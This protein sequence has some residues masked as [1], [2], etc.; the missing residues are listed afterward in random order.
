[1]TDSTIKRLAA[2]FT[3]D[4]EAVKSKPRLSRRRSIVREFALTTTAHGIPGIARSETLPNRIFWIVI[5]LAFSGIMLYFVIKSILAYFDYQT[6]TQVSLADEWPQRF[7][8]VTICNYGALRFDRFIGP[9]LNYT[10]QSNI[11]IGFSPSQAKTITDYFQYKLGRNESLDDAFFPL[12]SMLMSC[13]Y[14]GLS[15][16]SED[17][18]PFLSS[19]FGR[20]YS[21]NIKADHVRNGTFFAS[22]DNGQMGSLQLQL[23]AH[24]HQYVPYL[25]DGKAS[26]VWREDRI[27]KCHSSGWLHRHAS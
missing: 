21:L 18:V 5:T 8:A 9:F 25:T 12:S 1:M 27:L 3:V 20:C 2:N 10:N 22:G 6:Q 23:Y 17:F 19:D 16:S 4:A 24:G 11:A 15:C 26:F 7:P 13:V 14:N